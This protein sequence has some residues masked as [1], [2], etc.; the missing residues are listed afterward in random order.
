MNYSEDYWKLL[1]EEKHRLKT[2]LLDAKIREAEKNFNFFA[3][4][5]ERLERHLAEEGPEEERGW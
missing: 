3:T 4:K 1:S 5:K 2:N